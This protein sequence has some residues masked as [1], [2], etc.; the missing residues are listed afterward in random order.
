MI[1]QTN[2]EFLFLNSVAAVQI[3]YN[4]LLIDNASLGPNYV[5]SWILLNE[6]LSHQ[7]VVAFPNN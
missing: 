1:P 7:L 6:L 4:H 2:E 3:P 5:S